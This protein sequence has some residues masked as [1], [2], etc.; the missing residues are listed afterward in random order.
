MAG[1]D[2]LSGEPADILVLAES[3]TMRPPSGTVTF[4]FTDVQGST[5]LWE[6]FPEPMSRSLVRHEALLRQAIQAQDGY[7]F[8]TAG[9]AFCTAFATAPTALDAAIA[10]QEALQTEAWEQM[11]PLRIRMALHTGIAEERDADY[12]GSTLNRVARLLAS[13]HGGQIL[14][15]AATQELVRDHLPGDVRLQD[16]GQVRL[17]DLERPE[18]VYQVL[19]PALPSDFPSLKSLDSIPNNL[20]EQLTSFVGRAQEMAEVR[21]RLR[22]TRLLTL[23]GPGGAG[24]SRLSLQVGADVLEEYGSGV[25][26]IELAS[27]SDP[28]LVPQAIASV[29]RVPEEPGRPLEE[30]LVESLKSKRLLL[31]LDNCEHLLSAAAPLTH[32][33]LRTCPDLQILATSREPLGIPGETTYRLPAL[34]LPDPAHLPPVE[35][36]RQY[37]AV[38]L[39]IERAAAVAPAFAVNNQNAPALA[40]VC[41]R[42]DGIPL[43]IELAAARIRV[44]TV[45]EI[46]ARLEDRFRLLTGGSRMSLPH[47]QTLRALIDWSYDLL[48]D[49][50]RLLFCR[51]SVFMGGW[52]LEAAEVVC[53]DAEIEAWEILDLLTGLVD[54]SLVMAEPRGGSTRYRLLETVRQYS[55]DRLRESEEE[56]AARDRHR[57][58]FLRL[59]EETQTQRF[60]PD[61]AAWFDHLE[62]EHDNLRAALDWCLRAGQGLKAGLR[63]GAALVR[64]WEMHGHITE[65]RER[66]AA[67]LAADSAL[68]VTATRAKA[69]RGASLLAFDQADITA[70]RALAEESLAIERELG[71]SQRI[72]D[73]LL[74]VA[75]AAQGQGDY[76]SA[77]ALLGESLELR[78]AIG[79]TSGMAGARHSMSLLAQKQGDWTAARTF[80][81]EGLTLE[82]EMG[83]KQFIAN[84]LHNLGGIAL[85]EGNYAAA[86]SAFEE[87]LRLMREQ[88]NEL[89]AALM[90]AALGEV[91]KVQGDPAMAHT[92]YAES[93]ALLRKFGNPWVFAEA[94][95]R[96]AD[97]ASAQGQAEK[98]L[99]LLGAAEALR[100]S[101]RVPA[102]VSERALYDRVTAEAQTQLPPE[103]CAAA[104]ETGQAMPLE[105]ALD[106][107][108]EKH[109]GRTTG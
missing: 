87:A 104:K 22:Q 88:G 16:M 71:E 68:E 80:G 13:G 42:L 97:L 70:Q 26:L 28:A 20:P 105:Q 40:Q 69:L 15:S 96:F 85:H 29:L 60:Q 31:I 55:L 6:Q 49:R 74:L 32:R 47:Q 62:T 23:I 100:Q 56:A 78:R 95:E 7:V 34:S 103:T 82:R 53:A 63:L 39:F 33:L 79:D 25:W 58:Y 44:L 64:F 81:E 27:L 45:E 61:A 77:Q 11:V 9:D 90:L 59:A 24:K 54:K 37:E 86:H 99:V 8:K 101:V 72:A 66:L 14:V 12:F 50:E 93:L 91:A 2:S 67:F 92:Y 102:S 89:R 1:K 94:L 35:S 65:G 19:H 51:L 46:N 76:V 109:S 38:R 18:H 10:A 36:L 75:Y 73:T 83:N 5:R 41:C 21:D 30:A 52:I 107:A 48:T 17:R 106:Y 3:L 4:L 108:L 84:Q 57:D 98:A 43:A